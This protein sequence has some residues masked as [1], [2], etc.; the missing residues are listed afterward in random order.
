MST[1]GLESEL[2]VNAAALF[3]ISQGAVAFIGDCYMVFCR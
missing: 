3:G 1:L 2:I